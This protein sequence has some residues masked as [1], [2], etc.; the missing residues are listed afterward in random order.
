MLQ[1]GR[2]NHRSVE[3]L[4]DTARVWRMIG[5]CQQKLEAWQDSSASFTNALALVDSALDL[6]GLTRES[7]YSV[8]MCQQ[9]LHHLLSDTDLAMSE[10]MGDNDDDT[11][12]AVELALSAVRY[13]AAAEAEAQGVLDAVADDEDDME[14][15]EALMG[16]K[17]NQARAYTHLMTLTRNSLVAASAVSSTAAKPP[18]A[19]HYR[20]L[21]R[22]KLLDAYKSA[23]SF[24]L[25]QYQYL[26][27]YNLALLHL[28]D[29]CPLEALRYYQLLLSEL[30]RACRD[31]GRSRDVEWRDED[32]AREELDVQI[33]EGQLIRQLVEEVELKG[34]E[35]VEWL[36]VGFGWLN[37]AR[38]TVKS[39]KND[40]GV[41]VA[42]EVA[43]RNEVAELFNWMKTELTLRQGSGAAAPYDAGRQAVG[44]RAAGARPVLA[45]THA[46]AVGNAA[47]AARRQQQHLPPAKRQKPLG[48]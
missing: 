45:E 46:N 35:A 31:D 8:L 44:A 16:A 36:R 27:H 3:W 43:R 33:A 17:I 14:V 38:L 10:A 6:A 39:G 2:P 42:L 24:K 48:G 41:P 15:K 12:R 34:A 28:A 18:S 32:W 7:R 13:G 26:A 19:G 9:Q 4:L 23:D 25:H 37:A 20:R 21:A 30:F 29:G 1:A 47:H 40:S 11:A 5:E 22:H